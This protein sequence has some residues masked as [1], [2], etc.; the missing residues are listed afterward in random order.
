MAEQ[1]GLREID[2]QRTKVHRQGLNREA[3]SRRRR[4]QQKRRVECRPFFGFASLGTRSAGRR[5]HIV[6]RCFVS[7]AFRLFIRVRFG[8]AVFRSSAVPG[9]VTRHSH[10]GPQSYPTQ[11]RPYRAAPRDKRTDARRM[12]KYFR[13]SASKSGPTDGSP[14]CQNAK[15]RAFRINSGTRSSLPEWHAEIQIRLR[16]RRRLFGTIHPQQ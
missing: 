8:H 14:E 5:R 11:S 7:G 15:T 13:P 3:R 10:D 6:L 4:R 16:P 12:S 9:E 1:A 2:N